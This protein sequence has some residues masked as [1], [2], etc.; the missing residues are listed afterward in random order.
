MAELPVEIFKIGE[1]EEAGLKKVSPNLRDHYS[2]RK[3]FHTSGF[4]ISKP[5]TIASL[6]ESCYNQKMGFLAVNQ[7]TSYALSVDEHEDFYLF[8]TE[9]F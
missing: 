7:E 1:L 3:H 4:F 2:H 6:S 9:I 5:T 8:M